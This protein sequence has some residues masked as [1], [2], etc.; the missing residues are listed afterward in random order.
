MSDLYTEQAELRSQY[1]AMFEHNQAEKFAA[2]ERVANRAC[3]P[4]AAEMAMDVPEVK[5]KSQLYR[6]LR[7]RGTPRDYLLERMYLIAEE[8]RRANHDPRT[9][10]LADA[11]TKIITATG[12]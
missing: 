4:T 11:I 1:A 6:L 5:L 10:H 12:G 7:V 2:L 8:Y 9:N 3:P